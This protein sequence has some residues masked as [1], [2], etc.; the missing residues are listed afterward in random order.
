[1]YFLSRIDNAVQHQP[2]ESAHVPSLPA[3]LLPVLRAPGVPAH[4]Q[5]GQDI[6][7]SGGLSGGQGQVQPGGWVSLP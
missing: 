6:P 1:M 4:H 3:A 5:S 7:Q 2:A